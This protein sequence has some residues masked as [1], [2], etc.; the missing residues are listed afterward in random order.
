MTP[1]NILL[2][3]KPGPCPNSICEASFSI[4]GNERDHNWTMYGERDRLWSTKS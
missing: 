4:D 3:Y 1:N 2:Y